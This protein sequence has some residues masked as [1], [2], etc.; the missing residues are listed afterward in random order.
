VASITHFEVHAFL[1]PAAG[2][3]SVAAI[4]FALERMFGLVC[5]RPAIALGPGQRPTAGLPFITFFVTVLIATLVG[6]L[7][8]LGHVLARWP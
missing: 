1:G 6:G 4:L 3:R 7:T 8:V 2:R 5:H